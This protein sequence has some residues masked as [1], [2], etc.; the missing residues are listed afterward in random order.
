ML[1]LYRASIPVFI[2]GFE[3]LSAILVK[4][5]AHALSLGQDPSRLITARLAPDMLNLAGQV[6]RARDTAKGCAARL[7]G[8][9]VPRFEDTESTFE[10]VQ[11]RIGKTVD[12]L[13]GIS[14]AQIDGSEQKPILLQRAT[15]TNRFVGLEY[16]LHY[17]LPSFYFHVSIAYAILR[18]AGV[19]IGKMDYLGALRAR[20][21]GDPDL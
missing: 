4:G 18:H 14:A 15:E 9:P 5:H 20:S 17:C 21:T 2:R 1:S 12:F 11:A 6:Q 8:I 3:S 10:E 19:T 16:L 13:R 7:A